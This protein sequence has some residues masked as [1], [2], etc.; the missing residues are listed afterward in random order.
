[1]LNLS[2]ILLFPLLW[3]F[4]KHYFSPSSENTDILLVRKTDESFLIG[5]RTD[6]SRPEDPL[7]LIFDGRKKVLIFSDWGLGTVQDS[8]ILLFSLD[9]W[10][11]FLTE[12]NS[13]IKNV[14]EVIKHF[15]RITNC[16]TQISFIYEVIQSRSFKSKNRMITI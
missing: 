12:K 7:W 14:N 15:F 1:M 10:K 4:K 9:P 16:E 6:I 8:K 13:A 3:L 11:V 5:W 2:G